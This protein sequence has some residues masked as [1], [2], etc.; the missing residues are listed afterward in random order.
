MIKRISAVKNL[1]LITRKI[2]ALTC[3]TLGVVTVLPKWRH[4][5]LKYGM[6]VEWRGVTG[7]HW[8]S[9]TIGSQTERRLGFKNTKE[10]Y[11]VCVYVRACAR[12]VTDSSDKWFPVVVETHRN[13]V[14]FR[15]KEMLPVKYYTNK[16]ARINTASFK[17]FLR[18]TDATI[19][20]QGRNGFL[21]WTTVLLIRKNSQFQGKYKSC[22]Y[23]QNCTIVLQPHDFGTIRCFKQFYRKQLVL[24]AVYLKELWNVI[25]LKQP[26]GLEFYLSCVPG[27]RA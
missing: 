23:P 11:S 6:F 8:L 20:L 16:K 9:E 4:E 14:T 21:F 13:H 27:T 1:L 7:W 17:E 5:S 2:V 12:V 22:N 18:A 26:R 3:P 24:K 19:G 25:Q 15:T 10:C